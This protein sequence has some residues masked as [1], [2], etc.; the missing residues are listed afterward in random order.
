MN[1]MFEKVVLKKSID[2]FNSTWEIKIKNLNLRSKLLAPIRNFNCIYT[3]IMHLLHFLTRRKWFDTFEESLIDSSQNNVYSSLNIVKEYL[4]TT[5]LLAGQLIGTVVY[6]E[7]K[8]HSH[9]II[10]SDCKIFKG[11]SPFWVWITE[12]YASQ[13]ATDCFKCMLKYYHCWDL[14][15][16]TTYYSCENQNLHYHKG[17]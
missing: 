7:H 16:F 11:Q 14:N 1:L 2:L 6:E 9:K 17:I 15:N 12:C 8:L 10:I 5:Q 3:P 4:Y 13:S